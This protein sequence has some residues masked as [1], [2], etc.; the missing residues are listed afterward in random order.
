MRL[1][2][3]RNRLGVLAFAVFN[4]EI[5]GGVVGVYWELRSGATVSTGVSTQK[6]ESMF[7]KRWRPENFVANVDDVLCILEHGLM[8]F[9]RLLKNSFSLLYA[10]GQFL[11]LALHLMACRNFSTAC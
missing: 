10:A 11:K 9:N 8:T 1:I 7:T 4:D 2:K 6:I 5:Q 3:V